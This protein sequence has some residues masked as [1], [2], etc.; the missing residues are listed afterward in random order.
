MGGRPSHMLAFAL[1]TEVWFHVWF[2]LVCLSGAIF[3]RGVD[4]LQQKASASGISLRVGHRT[5]GLDKRLPF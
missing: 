3:G 4:L 1:I 2:G 5:L